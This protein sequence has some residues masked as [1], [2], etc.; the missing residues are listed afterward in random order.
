MSFAIGKS[1]CERD[2]T[3]RPSS[4]RRSL[5]ETISAI[6][7]LAKHRFVRFDGAKTIRRGLV[8][9]EYF[10]FVHVRQDVLDRIQESLVRVD[11]EN[12]AHTLRKTLT[13]CSRAL[14]RGTFDQIHGLGSMP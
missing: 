14:A 9:L 5:P 8:V 13:Q 3:I 2:T 11:N 4:L 1:V 12:A 6:R 10:H 7:Q